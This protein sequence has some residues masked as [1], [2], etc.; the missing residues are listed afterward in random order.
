MQPFRQTYWNISRPFEV[1]TYVLALLT[2]LVLLYGLARHIAAWRQGGQGEGLSRL[3]ERLKR[4]LLLG[5]FQARLFR[6]RE[7][8]L[9]HTA[10]AIA[11]VLLFIGTALATVDYDVGVLLMGKKLL[12]GPTYLVYELVLDLAGLLLLVGLGFTLYRRYIR[13]LPRL[14]TGDRRMAFTLGLLALVGVTGFAVEALRLEATRPPWSPWSP[15]GHL[16]ALCVGSL[17]LSQATVEGLHLATWSVHG[18]A[19]FLLVAT[20][21][22]MNLMHIISSPLR[23][24]FA[25]LRPAGAL[26]PVHGLEH[27]ERLGPECILDLEKGCLVALDACT[28]CGRCE[29]VCPAWLAGQPLSPRQVVLDLRASLA[30]GGSIL[31]RGKRGSDIQATRAAPRLA[32]EVVRTEAIWACT[33]CHACAEAC[34]VLIDP[35]EFIVELRRRLVDEGDLPSAASRML[36]NTLV[37]GSAWGQ[38]RSQR[39]AW[40]GDLS[41]RILKPGDSV[42][43]LYWVGDTSSFDGEAQAI[44]R[45]VMRLLDLAGVEYGIL[46]CLEPSDGEAARRMG[47]EGLFQAISRENSELLRQYRFERIL[48]HCP[49]TYN[50]LKNEYGDAGGR[51]ALVHHTE[52]LL[53]LLRQGRLRPTQPVPGRITYHDPCYLGRY[54]QVFDAPRGVLMALDGLELVEM[55][56]HRQ[57]ALCCGAGGGLAWV[58]VAGGGRV[59]YLRFQEAEDLAVRTVAT[60]CPYCKIMLHDAACYRQVEHQI[61]IRD[62]AEILLESRPMGGA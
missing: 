58:D 26:P 35:M 54:N 5:V 25:S 1:A 11:V 22:Y 7:A 27:R 39:P 28:K 6:E 30:P 4:L 36:E 52:F 56:G 13:R 42:E 44:P 23:I 29:V 61:R 46:G 53:E 43:L 51:W 34:P 10:I 50:T 2:A 48:T 15:V 24:L 59:N 21:P 57:T 16:L 37:L 20:I 12:K 47:E 40:V 17:G 14:L 49:H 33:T 3:S 31:K 18:A 19:A 38:A 9:R 32:G 55:K 8:G 45:A 41:S 60:A 62:I